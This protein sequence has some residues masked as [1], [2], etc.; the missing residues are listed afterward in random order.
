VLVSRRTG[1]RRNYT[2]TSQRLGRVVRRS[3]FSRIFQPPSEKR[4]CC[5]RKTDRLIILA[6]ITSFIGWRACCLKSY[7]MQ[8]GACA[9]DLNHVSV[10]ATAFTDS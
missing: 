7:E 8:P 1:I 10:F 2:K 5:M 3:V 9:L 4:L 6:D